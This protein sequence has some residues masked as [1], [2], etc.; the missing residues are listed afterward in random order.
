MSANKSS[1]YPYTIASDFIRGHGPR[2]C[3][4]AAVSGPTPKLSRSDAS[5][6]MRA[7]ELVFGLSHEEMAKRIADYA[8]A[9]GE[10][11]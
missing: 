1:R 7:F 11:S 3:V 9:T 4:A 5:Q 8:I 6:V 2:E 10:Q